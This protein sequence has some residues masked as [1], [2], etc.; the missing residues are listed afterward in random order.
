[1]ALDVRTF[2]PQRYPFEMLD[3][4]DQV[5]PGKSAQATKLVTINEWFFKQQ[6]AP[7][8]MPRPL[9]IEALAQTGVAALLSMP[10]YEGQNV[11]F[12]GIKQAT[13]QDDFRPGDCL[14]LQVQLVKIR[15]QIGVGHGVVIREGQENC[16]A[17]LIFVVT[18]A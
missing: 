9:V 14:T 1:M 5:T 12:G 15:H 11:F 13:F 16:A 17:D 7:L 2:I 4:L 10:E 18:S 8:A 6:Q 3:S